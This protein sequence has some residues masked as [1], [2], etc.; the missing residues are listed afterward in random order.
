[1]TWWGSLV[2]SQ[3]RLPDFSIHGR[4][5]QSHRFMVETAK[6]INMRLDYGRSNDIDAFYFS[7]GE[8]F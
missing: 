5:P 3:S 2:R 7:I 8:A 4:D 1:L 6:R